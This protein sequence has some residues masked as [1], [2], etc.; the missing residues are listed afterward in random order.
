MS[1]ARIYVTKKSRK[2]WTCGKCRTELPIGSTVLS[3]A[4]GFRGVEQ[5][6]CDKPACYPTRAQRESS[7]VAEVYD[8]QDSFSPDEAQTL[9]DLET[10]VQEVADACSSVASQYQDNPMYDVNE[11]LQER[12]STLEAA[13]SD[14]GSWADSLESEPEPEKP[15]DEMTPEELAAF[16]AEHDEWIESARQAA[17]E[18]VDGVE[19]P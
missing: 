19:L 8:A 17:R 10:A 16:K 3:F 2:V 9:E 15:E 11:D 6:R 12:V 13:E 4:V 18:A 1:L 5:K 14:L 7:M